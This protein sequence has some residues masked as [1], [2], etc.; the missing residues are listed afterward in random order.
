MDDKSGRLEVEDAE[1]PVASSDGKFLAY[2]RSTKGRSRMW[3]RPLQMGGLE[4]TPITPPNLDVR[5]M[6]FFSDDSLVFAAA[7]NGG[8][9][10]LFTVDLAGNVRQLDSGESR[11]PSVS[12]DGRWLAYSHQE[13]A[14]LNLWLRDLHTSQTSRITNGQCNDMA[15][16]WEADSQTLIFASDCGRALWF[17]ALYRRRVIP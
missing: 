3:L 1:F 16:A 8:A 9:S 6:S 5:E 4:D 14:V 11:Y 7:P 2:L 15:P 13:G 12:P 17:T 10:Q